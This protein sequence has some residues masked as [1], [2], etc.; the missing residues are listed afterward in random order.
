MCARYLQPYL[1][2]GS[3]DVATRRQYCS[4]L[5]LM[6]L[7]IVVIHNLL[8]TPVNR[9]FRRSVVLFSPPFA[10]LSVNRIT[11]EVMG[12]FS[13]NGQ[14]LRDEVLNFLSVTD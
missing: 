11:Q 13:G 12:E 1:V 7:L 4:N 14:N 5:M 3:R 2:D 9:H 6:L 8:T 10:C